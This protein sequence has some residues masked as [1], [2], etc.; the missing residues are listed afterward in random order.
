MHLECECALT[1]FEN[2]NS[3]G[4]IRSQLALANFRSQLFVTDLFAHHIKLNLFCWGEDLSK[5]TEVRSIEV[6]FR[7]AQHWLKENMPSAIQKPFSSTAAAVQSLTEIGSRTLA[8]IG[9]KEAAAIPI[10]AE[11]IQSEPNMTIFCKVEKNPPDWDRMDHL[12]VGVDDFAESKSDSLIECA[13]SFN[14]GIASNW[15]VSDPVRRVGIFEM[16]SLAEQI[17]LRKFCAVVES[18]VPG[19]SLLGGYANKS[20]T[21][22]AHE[23]YCRT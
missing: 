16:R 7:Q 9:S 8:A 22:L 2:S 17:D 18:R 4:V 5:V 6:V 13:V 20:I 15:I 3:L 21:K 14:C 12:L 19:A 23:K 1:P 10:R 11:N